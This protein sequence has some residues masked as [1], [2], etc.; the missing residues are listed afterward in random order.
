MKSLPSILAAVFLVAVLA[1]YMC[2][3][4]VRSTE[5]AIIKKFGQADPEPIEVAEGDPSFFAGLHVKWPW[6][7]Q[8]VAKY[9][10]RI[11]LLEDRIEET[12]TRDSKQII[13][14]TYTGWRIADPYT[15]HTQYQDVE[16]GESALRARIRTHKK[17]VIG[18]HDFSDLVSTDPEDRKLDEIEAQMREAVAGVALKEFGIDIVMFGIKKLTLPQSVTEQVFKTMKSAQETKAQAYKSEGNAEAQRIEAEAMQARQRILA[19]VTNKVAEI[20]SEGQ[21]EVG[22]IYAQFREHP[23]LRIFLDELRALEEMIRTRTTIFMDTDM[24]P[25]NLWDS[26]KRMLPADASAALLKQDGTAESVTRDR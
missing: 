10:K 22:R 23:E 12:P 6:P 14:T 13:L 1:L 9:D 11:R 5:V 20:E 2:T 18:L 8:S 19:V 25:M 17:A 4:Q 3:F 15:F 7:I 16:A 24:V 21:A 26:A